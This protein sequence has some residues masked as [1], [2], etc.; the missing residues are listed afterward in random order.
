[1]WPLVVEDIVAVEALEFAALFPIAAA[2]GYGIVAAK[3]TK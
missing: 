2:V 1:M 3:Q